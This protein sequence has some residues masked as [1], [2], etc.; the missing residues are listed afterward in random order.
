[1]KSNASTPVSITL[2]VPGP[3]HATQRAR[4]RFGSKYL[5]D[6]QKQEKAIVRHEIV[7]NLKELPNQNLYLFENAV[8]FDTAAFFEVDLCFYMPTPKYART[9]IEM[10]NLSTCYCTTKPDVDNLAKFY[11]D[12]MNGLVYQDDAAIVKLSVSKYLNNEPHTKIV[13][14]AHYRDGTK[15]YESRTRV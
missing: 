1:M 15:P 7:Q 2:I 10:R 9:A 6:P 11:L 5:Y 13:V 14:T 8:Y 12:C 3:P 4:A